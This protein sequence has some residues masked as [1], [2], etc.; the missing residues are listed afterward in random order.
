MTSSEIRDKFLDYFKGRGHIIYKSSSLVPDDP[1]LL[2]TAAGMVQFKPFFLGMKKPDIKRAISI[3][4]CVR[5]TD[6]GLVGKTA[7]HMT[8]FEMLGNFSFGDYYK[9]EAI[10]WAWDFITSEIGLDKKNLWVTV[11][12]DDDEAVKAWQ[13][14]GVDSDRIIRLGE[15]HNF[16]A[17]GPTGPCGPCSE[18]IYDLGEKVSCDK[19]N[20]R[21]GECDCDRYLELWNLV[22]MQHDRDEAGKLHPLKNKGIDTGM[23]LERL[24]VVIQGV[25]SC[26][27]TDL[28][29]PIISKVKELSKVNDK[30]VFAVRLISDHV[31]A[32]TF[33]IAD[34]VFP[35]NEGRGYV[36]RRLIR[37]AVRYGKLVQAGSN[38]LS[39]VALSVIEPMSPQYPEL[40]EHKDYILATIDE[41][42]SKF[43]KTLKQGMSVL[44]RIIEEVKSKSLPNISGGDAFQLY[45]TYGFPLELTQ[46][47]TDE[48][49]LGVDIENFNVLMEEQ[50]KRS[51]K[52]APFASELDLKLSKLE[53]HIKETEFI[54]YSNYRNS[55][56]IMGLASDGILVDNVR[57]GQNASI[58]LD[59]TVFYA[60]AGGQV[61]DTGIIESGKG[62]FEVTT[63]EKTASGLIIHGGKVISGAFDIGDEVTARIDEQE[64]KAIMRNH[65][66]THVLHWALRMKFGTHIKQAG[67]LVDMNRLRFDFTHNKPLDW[68]Q[69]KEIENKAN[70]IVIENLPVRA[71]VTS[72]D[73][74]RESGVTALFGEKYGDFVRVVE[75]GDISKELCGGTHVSATGD[76]GNIKIIGEFSIGAN[77]RRVEAVTGYKALEYVHSVQKTVNDASKKLDTKPE[78]LLDKIDH[79]IGDR[80][81][82]EKKVKEYKREKMHSRSTQLADT[83]EK[84]GKIT[85]IMGDVKDGSMDDL[86]EYVDAIRQKVKNSAVIL[87]SSKNNKIFLIAGAT[88]E[89]LKGGF[90][91]NELIKKI[92]PLIGGGGGGKAE[93]AQAGGIKPTGI[94]AVFKATK[95]YV[96]SLEKSN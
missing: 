8:F 63:T 93:M 56:R 60:T 31:R 19:A 38:F 44:A 91:A 10:E 32:I 16:W 88:K 4:K 68:K 24:A 50:K 47:L 26:F 21:I 87:S 86:R 65:T 66:A 14:I 11:Y 76:I 89:A 64:R 35:S 2:L 73:Y 55:G 69:V 43:D 27:E 28:F 18:I 9:K 7:R 79:L 30:T 67:S 90:N 15:E 78:K 52:G 48:E 23:G 34:G 81:E 1:T 57:A 22:F 54:G 77:L 85:L 75:V 84:I 17:A 71:Y 82:L 39:K 53:E 59:K 40:S 49:G 94:S 29:E 45:D 61:G 25:S 58:V 74:A 96:E 46:E 80:Q 62:K 5:T 70:S 51:K 92:S 83:A 13:G 72:M 33:L 41:E 36:L 6:I 42:E 3:Q 12:L 37:R 20:C 95:E